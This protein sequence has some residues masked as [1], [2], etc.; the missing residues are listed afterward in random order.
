M[1]LLPIDVSKRLYERYAVTLM[2]PKPLT[3]EMRDVSS[4]FRATY[5]K[6]IVVTR[7]QLF[8]IWYAQ[9]KDADLSEPYDVG[10]LNALALAMYVCCE[11][12]PAF[13]EK[14]KGHRSQIE[15]LVKEVEGLRARI[16]ADQ[17]SYSDKIGAMGKVAAENDD[18]A[19]KVVE[20]T[21]E[22]SDLKKEV[23]ELKCQLPIIDE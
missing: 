22:N 18:L 23:D 21:K 1:E 11:R 12:E 4:N 19:S 13:K 6:G 14:P 17:K 7:E 9:K 3:E 15:T 2:D 10:V 8:W 5:E 20:L 16:I